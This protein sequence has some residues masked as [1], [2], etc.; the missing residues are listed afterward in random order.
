MDWL[1]DWLV[2]INHKSYVIKLTQFF[3]ASSDR[4]LRLNQDVIADKSG[5]SFD[6]KLVGESSWQ[7]NALSSANMVI[8]CVLQYRLNAI[9]HLE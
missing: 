1:I 8:L 5:L 9:L 2:D 4:K 3:T 6:C 7:Y